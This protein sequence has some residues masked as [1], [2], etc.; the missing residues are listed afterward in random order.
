VRWKTKIR[1]LLL[2]WRVQRQAESSVQQKAGNQHAFSYR[3]VLLSIVASVG[4]LPLGLLVSGAFSI[5]FAQPQRMKSR[6]NLTQGDLIT[7]SVP[8]IGQNFWAQTNGPQG[9]DGI[10]LATNSIGHVFLGTQE[11]GPE[12][13]MRSCW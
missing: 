13:M 9:G 11:R 6:A 2:T 5:V 1:D 8:A 7:A 10:A 12:S 3:R 4:S